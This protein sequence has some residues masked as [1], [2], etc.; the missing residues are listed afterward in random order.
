MTI[1]FIARH[2]GYLRNFDGVIGALAARGHQVR[3]A[4]E[5]QDHPSG[6]P[7]LMTA[8]LAGSPNVSVTTAPVRARGEHAARVRQLRLAIDYLRFRE[9]AYR[10]TPHL[11]ERAEARAPEAVVRWLEHPL[12]K[13]RVGRRAIGA[14]LRWLEQAVPVSQPIADWLRAE[15]PDAVLVTPLI[16]L[17]SPQFDYLQAARSLGLR[18]A[19]PVTS[20]D[21]LSSKALIRMEPDLVL[22]WNGVQKR[23]AVM[24]HGLPSTR[25]TVTG[26]Q[27]YDHWFTWLP[28]R[29]RAQFLAERGLPA[30][31]PFLLYVC[32]SLFRDTVDET[33]FVEKWIRAIRDSSDPAVRDAGILIRPH[34][35]RV[36]EWSGFN[37]AQ[38]RDVVFWG[39]LPVDE[40]TRSDY[41]DSVHYSAAVVG[42]NTSAFL[43]AGVMG[44]PVH[45]VVLSKYSRE[46]Q[47]GTIHFHYLTTVNGGLLHVARSF[48]EHVAQL[49]GPLTERVEHDEKS[50]RFTE[51]FIRPRGLDVP[52]TPLFV[53]AIDKLLTKPA[54][55]PFSPPAAGVARLLLPRVLARL[56]RT[57]DNVPAQGAPTPDSGEARGARKRQA[58]ARAKVEAVGGVSPLAPR[59]GKAREQK[60]LAG[61]ETP[62][63]QVVRE[64]VL[65]MA[66]DGR[67]IVV[68]PWLSEAGFELLYW[69]PFVKW[70]A[71]YARLDPARLHI[72][73]RG[74]TQSWYGGVAT[75][76]DDVFRYYTPEDFRAKNDQRI[77]EQK[78]VLKHVR[79]AG[80][81]RT[82]V[83][84]VASAHALTDYHVLHPSL[85]YGL[86][87]LFWKQHQPVTLVELFTQFGLIRE[88]DGEAAIRRQLPERYVVAKFYGNV[89]LPATAENR[90]FVDTLLADL[91]AGTD[92]VLLNP[93]VR[94]DDHDDFHIQTGGRV[95]RIDQL[96]EPETNLATQTAIIRGADAY[97]GSYG[98]FSYLAPLVGTD[99]VTFYSDPGGFRWDHLEVAKRV[100]AGVGGGGFSELD[101]RHLR[102]LQVAFSPRT[103]GTVHA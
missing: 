31:K 3:L 26:A 27:A 86:F 30:D 93:G 45:T 49:S 9:P 68:G 13:R 54:R 76:Y 85:M 5:R 53:A 51:A 98:G 80:F 95:H 82:I 16:E 62:E 32:S 100:F 14:F 37:F 11:R 44:R 61:S 24:Y 52:A 81:D 77:A 57:R 94:Y 64:E 35:A 90:H 65:R 4:L 8:L 87:Q 21:H 102:G 38:Y 33:V 15:A 7:E 71:R 103:G 23:E 46:N 67:P 6:S 17:G 99:T 2:S 41:F 19:L 43:E 22:V 18:T 101:V 69:V 34:P 97:V 40:K 75:H 79:L 55:P 78:G 47:E 28:R 50:R 58:S 89:G 20:W 60:V 25:V 63:A 12:G 66:A 36:D 29:T 72:V 74:G 1:L 96:L 39:S 48:E 84:Q 59:V 91:S 88:S 10:K 70:V 92:I 56:G 73:S 83:E 42:L